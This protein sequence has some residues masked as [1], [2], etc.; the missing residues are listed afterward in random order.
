MLCYETKPRIATRLICERNHYFVPRDDGILL[1]GATHE[2]AGFEKAT[3][4]EGFAEIERFAHSVLPVLRDRKPIKTWAGLR[5]GMKGRHPL[6]GA[7]PGAQ[8]TVRERGA[9]PQ[10][11]DARAR[12]G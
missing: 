6:M 11:I 1:V 8:A 5:P 9:L 12:F 3:T 7:V 4:P 2:K 10:W